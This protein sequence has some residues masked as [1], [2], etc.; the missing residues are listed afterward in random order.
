MKNLGHLLATSSA[1]AMSAAAVIGCG[2]ASGT[3]DVP[4][5]AGGGV[6]LTAS[7]L[8]QATAVTTTSTIASPGTATASLTLS[9]LPD[10][11]TT[12]TTASISHKLDTGNS[13]YKVACRRDLYTPIECPNPFVLGK[14][15]P[16]A[17]GTHHVD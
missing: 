7:S 8:K 10:A 11:A 6:E 15:S 1:I 17:E 9:N 5:I 14:T 13:T 16:L 12:D 4:D 3:G 2:G